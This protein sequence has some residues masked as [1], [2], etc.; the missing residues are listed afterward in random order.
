MIHECTPKK[1]QILRRI[2]FNRSQQ[3]CLIISRKNKRRPHTNSIIFSAAALTHFFHTVKLYGSSCICILLK[4]CL[5]AGEVSKNFLFRIKALNHACF[6]GKIIGQQHSRQ[7]SFSACCGLF[8]WAAIIW[9]A[10]GKK[11]LVRMSN[12]VAISAMLASTHH[13]SI[14]LNALSKG[15]PLKWMQHDWQ[16]WKMMGKIFEVFRR[17]LW[18]DHFPLCRWM[19]GQHLPVQNVPWSE[20]IIRSAII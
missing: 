16:Q 17:D 2:S 8:F 6:S 12:D 7:R 20:G 18:S 9:W 5:F 15:T 1:A 4:M 10:S 14:S 19:D 13:Y 11:S 3:Q